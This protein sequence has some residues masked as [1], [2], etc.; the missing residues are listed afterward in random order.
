LTP[1]RQRFGQPAEACKRDENACFGDLRHYKISQ[2]HQ[3]WPLMLQAQVIGGFAQTHGLT[4][5][6]NQP[7]FPL[8]DTARQEGCF[9][10]GAK[11]MQRIKVPWPAQKFPEAAGGFW[12]GLDENG[13][14]TRITPSFFLFLSGAQAHES[15]GRGEAGG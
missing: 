9:G 15:V 11:C 14:A 13:H 3:P 7:F 5:L 2:G 1:G 10:L 12:G 6:R 8:V 4:H